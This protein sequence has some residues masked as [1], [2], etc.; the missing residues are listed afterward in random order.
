ME[1]GQVGWGHRQYQRNRNVGEDQSQ[2]RSDTGQH[3]SLDDDL[4]NETGS[5][6]ADRSSN[7]HLAG[8]RQRPRQQK[9]DDIGTPNKKN[10]S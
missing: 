5:T 8:T 4:L 10:D 3:Q 9:I 7:G 2:Q 6:C 1:P